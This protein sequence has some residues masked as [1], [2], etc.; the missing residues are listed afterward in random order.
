MHFI[1]VQNTIHYIHDT[2]K[3]Q[4]TVQTE[5]V[6]KTYVCTFYDTVE[7]PYRP[8]NKTM[9]ADQVS[10]FH[11]YKSNLYAVWGVLYRT[12][13]Q[14]NNKGST[15]RLSVHQHRA[16]QGLHKPGW[17]GPLQAYLL[18]FSKRFKMAPVMFRGLRKVSSYFWKFQWHSAEFFHEVSMSFWGVSRVLGGFGTFLRVSIT[19]GRFQ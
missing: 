5:T 13:R 10:I 14:Y 7:A 6:N 4:Y 15:N 12:S 3:I 17:L 2:P 1:Q 19:S 8:P 11:V 9:V 16:V 18:S